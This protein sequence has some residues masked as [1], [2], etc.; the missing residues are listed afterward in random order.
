MGHVLNL[1]VKAILYGHSGDAFDVDVDEES[2][3]A[4]DMWM[5]TGAL[6]KAHNL[7]VRIHRSDQLT[8]IIHDLQVDYI[9]SSADPEIRK[10]VVVLD[11]ATRWLSKYY[12]IERLLK[13]RPIYAEFLIKANRVNHKTPP[14]CLEQASQLTDKDWDTL[15]EEATYHTA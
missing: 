6:G 2:Q 7:V 13:L 3:A 1:V 10:Q 8:K 5:K 14:R 15:C 11:N 9:A 12:M 4:H